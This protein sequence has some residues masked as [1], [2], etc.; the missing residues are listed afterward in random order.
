MLGAYVARHCGTDHGCHTWY[1][2]AFRIHAS[3]Q[4][5]QSCES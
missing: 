4:N 3:P 1:S 2:V 5:S